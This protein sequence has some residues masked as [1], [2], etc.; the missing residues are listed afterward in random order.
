MTFKKSIQAL[1]SI[2]S[3][4]LIVICLIAL[5]S[6]PQTIYKGCF[7]RPLS[8]HRRYHTIEYHTMLSAIVPVR[9]ETALLCIV[10]DVEEGERDDDVVECGSIEVVSR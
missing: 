9:K 6:G 7:K 2:K 10:L 4:D 8:H 1:I 5:L 3:L